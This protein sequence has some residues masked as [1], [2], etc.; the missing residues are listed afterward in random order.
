MIMIYKS[1]GLEWIEWNEWNEYDMTPHSVLY[2]SCQYA[3][4]H[5]EHSSEYPRLALG[6]VTVNVR[7][8]YRLQSMI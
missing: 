6:I 2:S 5:T 8:V 4:E 1:C 7:S 3:L